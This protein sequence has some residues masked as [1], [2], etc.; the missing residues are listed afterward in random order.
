MFASVFQ[1]LWI[2]RLSDDHFHLRENPVLDWLIAGGLLALGAIVAILQ[3]WL[4]VAI[5]CVLAVAMLLQARTREIIFDVPNN[6]LQISYRSAFQKRVVLEMGLSVI[7][8]AYLK[9]A[10]DDGTQIILVNGAGEEMG[11]SAHSRDVRPWKD[12]I[13]IAINAILHAAHQMH[14]ED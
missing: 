6:Q 1:R 11:L 8:R 5:A 10:D 12:E 13:V 14:Q 4:T 9:T 3:L 7:A 2:V